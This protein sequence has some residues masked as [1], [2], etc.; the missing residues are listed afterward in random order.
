MY[1]NNFHSV[2]QTTEVAENQFYSIPENIQVLTEDTSTSLLQND[3]P[4]E[5]YYINSEGLLVNN[6]NVFSEIKLEVR[7]MI[8]ISSTY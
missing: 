6:A 1:F 5:T 3:N 2:L 8:F 7:L 4:F